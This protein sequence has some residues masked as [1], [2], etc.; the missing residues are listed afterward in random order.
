MPFAFLLCLFACNEDRDI[1]VLVLGNS[2]TQHGPLPSE[3]WLG[4]WGMA[5]SKADSDFVHV[6]K[7]RLDVP[8]RNVDLRARNIAYWE[9]DL[10]YD[11]TGEELLTFQHDVLV[12]RLGEN[13]K[14]M[15][16]YGKGV[17]ELVKTFHG[18]KVIITGTFW[19]NP[20]MDSIY[21]NVAASHG[22]SFVKLSDL[23][24][25]ETNMAFKTYQGGVGAHPSDKGMRQIAIR[26]Y[27]TIVKQY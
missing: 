8:Y 10:N 3:G 23:A 15:D 13:V 16:G 9:N 12:I 2:I 26:I 7:A 19:A 27:N 6:L 17:E 25:D 5:A 18:K 1:R 22:Y 11:F 20:K 24:V 14:S 21:M 4:N